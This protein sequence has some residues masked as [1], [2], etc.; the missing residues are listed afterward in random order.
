MGI[1]IWSAAYRTQSRPQ[2][3]RSCLLSLFWM[4]FVFSYLVLKER[5]IKKG[6]APLKG[7]KDQRTMI[8]V[9]GGSGS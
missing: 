8:S 3:F 9:L 2:V 7:M 1:A 6:V 4:I 5:V